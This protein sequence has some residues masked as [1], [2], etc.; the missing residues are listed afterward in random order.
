MKTFMIVAAL[1]VL[2]GCAAKTQYTPTSSRAVAARPVNCAFDILSMRPAR[3]IEELGIIDFEGGAVSKTGERAGVPSSASQLREKIGAQVC[4]AGGEAVLT[5][6]NGLGQYVRAT[7][8]RYVPEA[9][10][11]K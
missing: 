5:E 3:G 6:V 4:G 10:A 1:C 11:S 2:A 9:S 7:V 8:V